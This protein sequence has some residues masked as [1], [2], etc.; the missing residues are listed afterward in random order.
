ML[1]VYVCV[2][3][4][5]FAGYITLAAAGSPRAKAEAAE[6]VARGKYLVDQV[7]MCGDC[8]T[9]RDDQGRPIAA[10]YLQGAPIDFKPTAPVPVWAE[11]ASDIAGLPGWEDAA[12]IKFLMTGIAYNQLPAR[13]PMPAY[14]FNRQDA[15]AVAAYLKSLA[16]A[17]K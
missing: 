9:P 10:K 15:E 3:L 12:A 8:H 2:L 4:I 11:K 6:K 16:P 14:R 17:G 7:G 13:P 5:S 1:R